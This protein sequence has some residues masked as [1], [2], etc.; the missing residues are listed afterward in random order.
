MEPVRQGLADMT[1]GRRNSQYEDASFA[2]FHLFGNQMVRC[3]INWIM[4]SDLKDIL[5]GYRV[6]NRAIIE[7]IPVISSA[8]KLKPN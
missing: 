2:I 6:F 3:C 4:G 1:V 8:L 5:S 7:R